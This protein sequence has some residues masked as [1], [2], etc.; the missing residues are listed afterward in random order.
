MNN[1]KNIKTKFDVDT[2]CQLTTSNF[3]I[4]HES[5]IESQRSSQLGKNSQDSESIRFDYVKDF[6]TPMTRKFNI[7]PRIYAEPLGIGSIGITSHDLFKDSQERVKS[8]LDIIISSQQNT[9]EDSLREVDFMSQE[10]EE[11]LEKI[12]RG[13]KKL[14]K[15][16]RKSSQKQNEKLKKDDIN[17]RASKLMKENQEHFK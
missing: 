16:I 4:I 3:M 9:L 10:N 8:H 1:Q 13:L 14:K 15:M 17:D 12:E 7:Q 11:R 2:L 6:T 5:Q